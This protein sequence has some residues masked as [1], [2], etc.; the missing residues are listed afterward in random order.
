MS[1]FEFLMVF[2]SII[3]GLGVAEVLTGIAQQIRW[4]ESIAGYWVWRRRGVERTLAAG[5]AILILWLATA[6]WLQFGF[7]GVGYAIALSVVAAHVDELPLNRRNVA[8]GLALGAAATFITTIGAIAVLTRMGV[9]LAYRRW[10]G[11][12][13][14]VPVAVAYGLLRI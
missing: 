9:A 11:V 8:I 6:S 14:T 1:L 10:T 12:V 7:A 13:T 5:L 3:V 2:V 4:R